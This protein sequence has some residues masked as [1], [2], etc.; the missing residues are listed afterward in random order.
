MT[1]NHNYNVP[2]EGTLDWHIPLNENFSSLER[3]V[4]VRDVELNIGKYEPKTN[5]KFF[6]TD[7]GS[8]YIG[9]E[10]EW[11]FVGRL[12]SGGTAN[13]EGSAIVTEGSELQSTLDK[14]DTVRV[15]GAVS[16]NSTVTVP[17]YTTLY[18]WGRYSYNDSA[19]IGD[20]IDSEI[21]GSLLNCSEHARVFGLGL[22]NSHPNGRC[23]TDMSAISWYRNLDMKFNAI[24]IQFKDTT[25]RGNTVESQVNLCRFT[26]GDD[27][28]LDT[29]GINNIDYTDIKVQ[30]NVVR[31]CN[32]GI[33]DR[34]G[35][36]TIENNH[37][38]NGTPNNIGRCNIRVTS[39]SDGAIRLRNNYLEGH[40]SQNVILE[41][42][43]FIDQ[44]VNNDFSTL[45]P[46]IV[47]IHWDRSDAGYGGLNQVRIKDN[48]FRGHGGGTVE[49]AIK[50]TDLTNA[51][52][53][54]IRG[55]QYR[56]TKVRN[57]LLTSNQG[58]TTRTG[59]GS[60]RRYSW[61][62]G[63]FADQQRVYAQVTAASTDATGDFYVTTNRTRVTIEYAEP[64]ADGTENLT[65]NW[66]ANVVQD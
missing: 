49:T 29:I 42:D 32:Q 11:S 46:N 52:D 16:I 56:K 21:D 51:D 8:V 3:D 17:P 10:N 14:N 30:N 27:D 28:Y 47:H 9:K 35:G 65:W 61:E 31:R 55:N 20:G 58:I 54:E 7:T 43:G 60:S 33:V 2:T 5:A 1:T 62:H 26:G 22:R 37:F 13:P 19:V 66:S 59:D 4:E 50:A 44:I 39:D 45:R 38:Y 34:R 40:V 25:G 36:M 6:A 23:I 53:A 57:E 15:C 41:H 24:G 64:P 48:L 18:G 63:L 12:S